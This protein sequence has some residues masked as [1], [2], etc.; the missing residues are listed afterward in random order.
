MVSAKWYNSLYTNFNL[1][2]FRKDYEEFSAK[3]IERQNFMNIPNRVKMH[4]PPTKFEEC[5]TLP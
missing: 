1:S 5:G 2:P 3:T 4:P